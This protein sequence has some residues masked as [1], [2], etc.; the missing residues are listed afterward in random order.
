MSANG[1]TTVVLRGITHGAVDYLLKPVRIEE[2][3]NIWQHVVRKRREGSSL[4]DFQVDTEIEGK[5]DDDRKARK[6]KE[7]DVEEDDKCEEGSSLKKP[8]VVWSVELHQQFVN[9]VNQLGIDKAVPKRILDLM[10]VQ[11]LTR[12]NVAS[13]LQK[14]RLYLKRLQ[15]VT[16]NHQSALSTGYISAVQGEQNPVRNNVAAGSD[17]GLPIQGVQ[18]NR[19]GL[20]LSGTVGTAAQQQQQLYVHN[21]NLLSNMQQQLPVMHAQLSVAPGVALTQPIASGNHNMPP[22]HQRES[23][24]HLPLGYQQPS[25]T[26]QGTGQLSSLNPNLFGLGTNTQVGQPEG[27]LTSGHLQPAVVSGID[28]LSQ[29][30]RTNM[31]TMDSSALTNSDGNEDIMSLF[32]KDGNLPE[33]DSHG[34]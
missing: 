34:P 17:C 24:M 28:E 27:V 13:H 7:T 32:L 12:E 20:Q 6:R 15:G 9:A 31:F 1:D 30:T 2:L 23:G 4:S 18:L 33:G 29:G 16:P 19:S 26:P 10:G 21:A 5:R 3:R 11:G 8:R 25:N 22:H 14:Y